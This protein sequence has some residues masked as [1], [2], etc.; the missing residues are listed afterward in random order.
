ME[1]V[2]RC[3]VVWTL[4]SVPDGVILKLGFDNV[5]SYIVTTIPNITW[6]EIA[7]ALYYADEDRAMERAKSYIH[8]IAGERTLHV[9]VSED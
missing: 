5:A 1:G 9:E 6:E 3:G 2:W 7:A 4:L 8:T